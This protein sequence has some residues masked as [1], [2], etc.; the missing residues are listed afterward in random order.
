MK[1]IALFI[2]M[3]LGISFTAAQ[4]VRID[5]VTYPTPIIPKKT[6]K[7][8]F[9]TD[10]LYTLAIRAYGYEQF[11]QVL[12]QADQQFLSSYFNGILFK[13][14]D[15]QIGYRLQVNYLDRNISFDN[16][17]QGCAF[18]NGRL[19][20]TAVKAGIEKSINYS[21]IQP[22]LGADVGF[23]TQKFRGSSTNYGTAEQVFTEDI[24]NALLFSPL[25]GFKFYLI[26]QVAIGAEANLNIAYTY[27]KTNAF[28]DESRSGAPYQTK[29]YKWEYFFAPV[30]AISLQYN[31]GL[32]NQ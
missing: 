26:P 16:G 3:C 30:A 13:L 29:R 12:E 6:A 27:Q 18:A 4:V 9:N 5:T 14:N 24:K 31:F 2:T 19:Q 8:N 10:Y 1:F 11:P 15:N 17:C 22:Y 25:V 23:M 28:S 21:R 20:N 32:I 7:N